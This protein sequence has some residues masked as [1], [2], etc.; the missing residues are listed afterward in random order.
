ETQHPECDGACDGRRCADRSPIGGACTFEA[1]CG[2]GNACVGGRCAVRVEGKL[3]GACPS[4]ACESGARCVQGKCVAPKKDG[5]AC[6]LDAE[7][8]GGCVKD[9]GRRAGVCG[10]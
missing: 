6:A 4:G 7:C 10:M 1:M 8:A 5:E 9:K 2:E 3:G